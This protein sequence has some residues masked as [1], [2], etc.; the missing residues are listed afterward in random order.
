MPLFKILSYKSIFTYVG[1]EGILVAISDSSCYNR[2][3]FNPQNE[4]SI[5][6]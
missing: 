3:L 4:H 1:K 5:N 6:L 2:F